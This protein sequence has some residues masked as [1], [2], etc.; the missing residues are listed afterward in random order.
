MEWKRRRGK[1]ESEKAGLILNIQKI[2]SRHLSDPITSWQIDGETVKDFLFLG[3]KIT[4]YGNCS[5]EIIKK[6]TP[7]KKS[8]VIRRHCIKKQTHYFAY[9]AS[10]S[11]SEG[12]SSSHIWITELNH[13]GSWALKI[14]AFEMWCWRRLLRVP[15]TARRSK[16]SIVKG[17]SQS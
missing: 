4:T 5:H 9:K 7:W 16:Q 8:Y 3:S 1:E 14:D 12:L 11:H 2:R 15:W 17:S 13:K 10:H 6:I